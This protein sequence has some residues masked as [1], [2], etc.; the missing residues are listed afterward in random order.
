MTTLRKQEIEIARDAVAEFFLPVSRIKSL[1]KK[2]L[3]ANIIDEKIVEK[4][5]NL[6]KTI[7]RLSK[8]TYS[9][10]SDT[11]HL[12]YILNEQKYLLKLIG[13]EKK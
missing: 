9:L 4:L 13:T 5:D 10:H 11:K 7:E 12:S 2:I 1:I 6:E 3:T 8:E